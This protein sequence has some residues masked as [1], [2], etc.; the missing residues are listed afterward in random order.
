M[1]AAL[2][3]SRRGLDAVESHGADGA[4]GAAGAV[5]EVVHLARVT[6]GRAVH[7]GGRRGP[8]DACTVAG[9]RHVRPVAACPDG[10]QLPQVGSIAL[11]PYA[12]LDVAEAGAKLRPGSDQGPVGPHVGR[13]R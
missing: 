10:D 11:L 7:R 4:D 12:A 2:A 8:V 6:V 5:P 3:R 13:R 1:P 9:P